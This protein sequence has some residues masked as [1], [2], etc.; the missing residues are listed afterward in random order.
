M[1]REIKTPGPDHPITSQVAFYS[2]RA[3]L[4]VEGADGA[5]D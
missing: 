1:S 3:Q 2:D 5:E 4:S